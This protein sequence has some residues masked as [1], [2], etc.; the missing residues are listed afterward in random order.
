LPE[1]L[2]SLSV[3]TEP[4]A[5]DDVRQCLDRWSAAG[6]ETIILQ[7]LFG[8]DAADSLWEAA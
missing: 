5:A 1:P 4:D 6:R 2:Q 8:K 3:H 7:S